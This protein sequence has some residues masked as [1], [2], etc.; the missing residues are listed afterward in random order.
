M[1][2]D[3]CSLPPDCLKLI[4]SKINYGERKQEAWAILSCSKAM[5]KAVKGCAAVVALHGTWNRR[6]LIGETLSSL[7][8]FTQ[9]G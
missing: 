7:I 2:V 4:L 8:L 1:R 3:L 9:A 5:H 6:Q